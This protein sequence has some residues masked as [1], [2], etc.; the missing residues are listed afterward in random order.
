MAPAS[1]RFSTLHLHPVLLIFFSVLRKKAA[2]TFIREE[3]GN[4]PTH[5]HVGSVK[6]E[7][8]RDTLRK[9]PRAADHTLLLPP[10]PLSFPRNPHFLYPRYHCLLPTRVTRLYRSPRLC[11]EGAHDRAH[12]ITPKPNDSLF[13][14][15]TPTYPSACPN[16]C[17]AHFIAF[18]FFT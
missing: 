7:K 8:Q 17:P 16:T 4:T 2:G 6:A 1:P 12:K 14:R 15:H 3:K 5:G 18:L 13:G 10:P 9:A 11:Q